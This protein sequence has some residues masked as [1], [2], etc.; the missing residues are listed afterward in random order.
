[1]T[2]PLPDALRQ[3]LAATRAGDPAEATRLIQ[4]A[5]GGAA[6]PPSP[7]QPRP[8]PKPRRR[9]FARV[10]PRRVPLAD[11]ASWERRDHA[12]PEGA[13]PWRLMR[14]AG[15]VSGV[16]VMLHG[17]RQDPEDFARGTAMN[18]AAA[19]HGLAVAWPEQPAAAN[20]SRCWNWFVP[21][22]QGAGGEPA[23]LAAIARAAMAETGARRAG[24]A[25]LSAGAAMAATLVRHHPGTFRAAALHSGLAP[26]AARDV[27]SAFA[28]MRDGPGT[29]RAG[30][31][32]PALVIHG[33]A[34]ATVHPANAQAL[35][36]SLGADP[37][38]GVVERATEGGRDVERRRTGTVE[39]WRVAGLGHAWS[40]GSTTGRFAD[41]AGPDASDAIARFMARHLAGG[42][43][44]P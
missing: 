31:P 37:A 12:G 32:V 42:D 36:R 26:E 10:K 35:V 7:V 23:I 2:A 17:C 19:A 16:L 24:V 21:A 38:G 44:Q 20:P 15:V 9:P 11:G 4:Q 34:D 18:L 25:G 41:P 39:W 29:V 6:P 40:G 33:E 27:P 28:A 30:A 3:A 13:R 22:H 43:R 1:M 5:L 8:E 14:P